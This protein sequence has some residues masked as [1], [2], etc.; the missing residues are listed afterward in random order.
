MRFDSA[1]QT[2]LE[3]GVAP[4]ASDKANEF[5]ANM[6]FSYSKTIGKLICA[7][8][9]CCV[10]ILYVVLNYRS[11]HQVLHQSTLLL[12]KKIRCLHTHPDEGLHFW[13]TKL[14]YNLPDTPSPKL[15]PKNHILVITHHDA[16]ILYGYVD[17]NWTGEKSH[18]KSFIIIGIM[19][20]GAV[21]EY[22]SKHRLTIALCST[23]AEFVT[24]YD[25]SKNPLYIRIMIEEL[26]LE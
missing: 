12:S 20:V 14:S 6:G 2:S 15:R 10:D 9:T 7:A 18:H 5:T 8:I 13:R 21:I 19:F 25:A 24:A 16:G 11:I 1:Y 26:N 17:S 23:E 3:T 4:L 22:F